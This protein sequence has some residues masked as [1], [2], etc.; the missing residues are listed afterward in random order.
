MASLR[1]R[2]ARH[3]CPSAGIGPWPPGKTTRRS[4]NQSTMWSQ[5]LARGWLDYRALV[6]IAGRRMFLSRHARQPF[7]VVV[8]HVKTFEFPAFTSNDQF[9]EQDFQYQVLHSEYFLSVL[10]T[11]TDLLKRTAQNT[12]DRNILILSAVF[13]ENFSSAARANLAVIMVFEATSDQ[14]L[15]L[16]L[17]LNQWLE[18]KLLP[19]KQLSVP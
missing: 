6:G 14:L 12:N 9:C 3:S 19:F 2:R 4:L 8:A 18:L 13:H 5:G 11:S 16:L 15:N 1:H 17:K 7:A 10:P